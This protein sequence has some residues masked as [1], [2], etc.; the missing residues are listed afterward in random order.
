MRGWRH[1]KTSNQVN[2]SDFG[3]KNELV[4]MT[5]GHVQNGFS[6]RA[7]QSESLSLEL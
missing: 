4:V 7:L 2:K 3:V 5:F 1:A 6:H